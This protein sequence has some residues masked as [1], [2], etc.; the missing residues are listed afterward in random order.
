VETMIHATG[1][2][3]DKAQEYVNNL[4]QVSLI[5]I[6]DDV[7]VVRGIADLDDYLRYIALKEKFEKP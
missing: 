7:L 2:E 3:K 4:Q 5:K 1:I 6:K